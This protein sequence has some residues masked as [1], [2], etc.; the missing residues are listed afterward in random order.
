MYLQIE[1]I[2]KSYGDAPV[3]KGISA[4]ID[5]GQMCVIYGPSGSGKSTFLNIVGA[6]DAADSGRIVVDREEITGM[7]P[8]ALQTAHPRLHLP[9]LQLSSQPHRAR[10]HS[11][12]QISCPK[13]VRHG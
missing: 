8:R 4:G 6:L 11:G 1:N 3:L 10:K 12:L 13:S 5:R 7:D 2:K 9:V